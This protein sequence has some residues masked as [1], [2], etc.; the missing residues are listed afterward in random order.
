MRIRNRV[1]VEFVKPTA[2]RAVGDRLAVDPISASTFVD[3][4]K[5]AIRVDDTKKPAP[6]APKPPPAPAPA[7]APVQ[8]GDDDDAA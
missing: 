7:P 4:L 8:V 6:A 2:K 1:L 5:V 3:K